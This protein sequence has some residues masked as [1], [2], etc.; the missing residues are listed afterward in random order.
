MLRFAK[1]FLLSFFASSF[2]SAV[3]VT[4][5]LSGVTFNDGGRAFGSFVYDASINTYSSIDIMTTP[6]TNTTSGGAASGGK[7]YGLTT[8]ASITSNAA[9]LNVLSIGAQAPTQTGQLLMVFV[10]Q[11]T[12]SG[13]SSQLDTIS[14]SELV[15]NFGGRNFSGGKVVASSGIGAKTWYLNHVVFDDGGQ[16]TGSFTYDSDTGAFSNVDVW[17]TGGIVFPGVPLHFTVARVA[18]GNGATNSPVFATK[19]PTLLG[20]RA[21]TTV[22][23]IPLL[24]FGTTQTLVTG[25]TGGARETSCVT[26]SCGL[27]D[28]TVTRLVTGGTL[29]QIKPAGYTKILSD[30]VDGGGFQTTVFITNLT[31]FPA[32]FNARFYQDNGSAFN[33]PGIGS[34]TTGSQTIVTV[35]PRGTSVLAST[36]IGVLGG[37]VA[38]GWARID[39]ADSFNASALFTLKKANVAGDVQ[40]SVF[41]EP[42]GMT[43]VSF[44][45]DFTNGTIGGLALTNSNP[46]VGVRVLAVAFDENGTVLTNNT[47]ITLPANG[48]TAFNFQ[49]QAGY[50]TLAGK[51]GV[52]RLFSFANGVD[53]A[54]PFAGVNGLLLQFLPNLTN[55]SIQAV[56]Q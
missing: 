2:L 28:P 47:N 7:N 56:H 12:D 29:T 38:Q 32:T 17:V 11:L 6:G 52:L 31:D 20:D 44:P 22:V 50:S 24:N 55:T 21:L 1:M 4:W 3:P 19:L 13:G 26:T 5:Y 16:A 36:G 9:Q 43:S 34:Q 40:N 27:L 46:T 18:A 15:P 33:I 41:G 35:P 30:V 8:V 37:A 51:R 48:H 54:P 25:A 49:N 23:S 14:I 45:F 42:Q 53:A 39:G 10:T